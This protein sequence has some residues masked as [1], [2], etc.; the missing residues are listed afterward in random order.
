MDIMSKEKR[1][2][3]MSKIRSKNTRCEIAL[4]KTL[5]SKGYRGYRKNI[6]LLGFEVD[7]LFSREK[8]AVFC[9]SDFWHGKKNEPPKTNRK[10]WVPKLKR[11]RERDEQASRALTEAGWHVVRLSEHDILENAERETRKVI[12]ILE[13]RR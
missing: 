10:Y 5:Y 12:Q 2:K 6:R 7:V 3:V 9:D 11:N 1:S 4:R 8:V 13:A